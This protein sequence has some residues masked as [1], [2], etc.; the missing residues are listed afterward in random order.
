MLKRIIIS[1][2]FLA[3]VHFFCYPKS[4]QLDEFSKLLTNYEQNSVLIDSILVNTPSDD[5]V[6]FISI[7]QK[8]FLNI[9][10]DCHNEAAML[11]IL[12]TTSDRHN[13]NESDSIRIN[14]ML[15]IVGRNAVGTKANDIEWITVEG[16]I[17]RLS[18]IDTEYTLLYFNDPDC[19]S[20]SMV[21]ERLDTC[22]TLRTLVENNVL[23]LVAIYPYS[24]TEQWQQ[25]PYPDY[26]VNGHDFK[27][28]VENDEAYIL[29]SM[30]LFYLLDKN[31]TVLIKNEPSLNR[32]LE[33]LSII[34][35]K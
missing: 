29:P 1:F 17:G 30:P 27:G 13:L 22:N 20:C 7:A 23:S 31:K 14:S 8:L 2:L 15:E 16:A 28:E 21:K 35:L 24:D 6:D 9:E 26:I 12:E 4:V 32:I 33:F 25:E 10:D 11:H 5:I 3:M 19:F 18:S 34:Q